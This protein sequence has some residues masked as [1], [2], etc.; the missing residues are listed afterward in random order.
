MTTA[1]RICFIGD[2]FVQGVGD[3]QY[4][5]WVGRV[6]AATG[7]AITAFNLG[8]RRDTS[9]DVLRRCWSEVEPRMLPGADNRLVVSF[10]ANDA[11]EED[12]APRVSHARCLDN[13]ATVLG[14]SRERGVAPLVVGPPPVVG[15][16][17]VHLRRAL[18]LAEEMSVLCRAQ[19]VPFVD[20]TAELAGDTVWVREA[21]DGDG[22][23]PG[24]GG[25]QRLADLVL[26]GSWHRWVAD[27]HG[28]TPGRSASSHRE[29]IAGEPG[30]R[31]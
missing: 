21:S 7:P 12:G 15:A 16:G 1:L 6:L 19:G 4:R 18:R 13:L 31:P 14:E 22:A 3:P 26:A 11:I 10:G 30:S 9:D 20:V 2:S 25:Y 29:V 27:P 28:R 5:G 17:A 23:H 24:A 8:V